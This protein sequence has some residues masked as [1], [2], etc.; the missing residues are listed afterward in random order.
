VD[1]DEDGKSEVVLSL[2]QRY[3]RNLKKAGKDEGY[4]GMAVAKVTNTEMLVLNFNSH[5]QF[6]SQ[7][8]NE[9][10]VTG[11]EI[12]KNCTWFMDFKGG[13]YRS[14]TVRVKLIPGEYV[15]IPYNADNSYGEF[16][17]IIFTKKMIHSQVVG[18]ESK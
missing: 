10:P 16:T 1:V 17:V 2:L 8:E 6:E 13:H 14:H 5:P 7:I 4:I 15:V 11:A 18:Y 12:F 3:R 9:Y